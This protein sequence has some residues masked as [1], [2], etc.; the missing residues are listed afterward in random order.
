MLYHFL[1]NRAFLALLG[2]F[3]LLL[4]ACTKEYVC[5]IPNVDLFSFN[6]TMP[7][8][9]IMTVKVRNS[10]C[11]SKGRCGYNGHGIIVYH[12]LD[13][14][15]HAFDATCPDSEECIASSA[16]KFDGDGK[17][18]ATCGRCG[19]QYYLRDGKHLKKKI[20]LRP[21]N[22]GRIPNTEEQYRVSNF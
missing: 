21:Y 19:S 5:P 15:V 20:L 22:V 13:G 10:G 8:A 3:A 9:N 14:E 4:T 11:D 17:V 6:E 12:Y 18:T 1:K 7:A 16:V 2:G